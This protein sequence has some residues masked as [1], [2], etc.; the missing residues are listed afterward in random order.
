MSDFER[1]GGHIPLLDKTPDQ[2]VAIGQR[3]VGSVNRLA[4]PCDPRVSDDPRPGRALVRLRR[5]AFPAHGYGA[6]PDP[7]DRDIIERG[8]PWH[9]GIGGAGHGCLGRSDDTT[10]RGLA[11]HG[12]RARRRLCRPRA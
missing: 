3:L 2:P 5:I 12:R 6:P 4:N 8:R 7:F 1:Y 11:D 10:V 9:V